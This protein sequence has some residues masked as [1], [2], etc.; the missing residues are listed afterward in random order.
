MTTESVAV[1]GVDETCRYL[2]ELYERLAELPCKPGR[3]PVQQAFAETL[4][5]DGHQARERLLAGHV[6]QIYADIT[7]DYWN[8]L[9]V[10]DLVAAAARRHPGLLP[11]AEHLAVEA[12]RPQ[13]DK[14]GLEIDLGIFLAHV[15]GDRRAGNHLVHAMSQPR[16]EA[17]E[18]LDTLRR[19]DFV[20]LGLA[21]VRRVGAVGHVETNN[22]RVLN[23]EDNASTAALEIAVDLVLLDDRIEIGVLRGAPAAHPKW[24]GRRIF[25]AGINLTDLYHGRISLVDFFV[26]REL[27]AVSKIYRGHGVG[28]TGERDL[29]IGHEKPWIGALEGF[30]IGGGCQFLLVLDWI[31]AEAGSYFQLPAGK[32]GIVPGCGP[33]RIGRFLGDGLAR[34]AVFENR[35]FPVDSEE[36]R[37]LVHEVAPAEEMDAAIDHAAATLLD[38]GVRSLTANRR[39]MRVGVE[40]L[41]VFRRYMAQYARDQAYCAHS[42]ALVANL[43][44]NWNAN[45]RTRRT[46]S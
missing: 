25:G 24:R 38:S 26:D 28:G 1:M 29:E 43:E 14:D 37:L 2:G 44:R 32:E 42:P 11:T 40:P 7:D 4:L 33:M 22:H 23:A 12:A 35:I 10:G 34:Q 41:D 15:L 27:G 20:D 31:V 21:S 5:A 45:N 16:R 46:A 6:G 39:A 3:S 9:R 17:L 18:L 36:G 13:K 19:S 30:A 8:S